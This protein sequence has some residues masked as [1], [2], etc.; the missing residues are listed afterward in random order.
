M[1]GLTDYLVILLAIIGIVVGVVVSNVT[2][3]KKP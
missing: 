3:D 2:G 1:A